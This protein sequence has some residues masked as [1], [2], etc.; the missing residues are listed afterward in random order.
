MKKWGL[1]LT[2]TSI[3]MGSSNCFGVPSGSQT[4]CCWT[5]QIHQSR[6]C[7][8]EGA[9]GNEERFQWRTVD[10]D[11]ACCSEIHVTEAYTA[12]SSGDFVRGS[13][14][15]KT[16]CE[17]QNKKGK[18]P[19]N[20]KFWPTKGSQSTEDAPGKGGVCCIED[21]W[22]LWST[23]S[24]NGSCCRAQGGEEHDKHC[25]F[26]AY[27][28]DDQ[29]HSKECCKAAEGKWKSGECCA[30]DGTGMAM[31]NELKQKIADDGTV[32]VEMSGAKVTSACCAG[33]SG[34]F[35]SAKSSSGGGSDAADGFCCNGSMDLASGERKE[36]CCENAGGKWT[37]TFCCASWGKKVDGA[38]KADSLPD[39]GSDEQGKT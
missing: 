12:H 36:E 10:G 19:G 39:S 22:R 26:G 13:V 4:P 20:Y 5:S 29:A 32:T 35:V 24:N 28:L 11:S 2:F 18:D 30:A 31:D 27:D 6:R 15:T 3:L 38:C 21:S 17:S 9:W 8:E 25:C 1:L 23:G 7:C 16:C 37:G 34:T 33:D 14:V